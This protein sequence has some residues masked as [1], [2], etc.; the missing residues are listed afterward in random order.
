M[1]TPGMRRPAASTHVKVLQAVGVACAGLL[2]VSLAVVA[3][4]NA[5][6]QL[7]LVPTPSRSVPGDGLPTWA[8][9]PRFFPGPDAPPDAPQAQDPPAPE[10]EDRSTP[11]PEAPPAPGTGDPSAPGPA[12]D[13]LAPGPDATDAPDVTSPVD[14]AE[15]TP[16]VE[17]G[18]VVAAASRARDADA[19]QARPS[20]T[21]VP[22]TGTAS[23]ARGTAG[24]SSDAR[25]Q[26]RPSERGPT[27]TGRDAP[28]TA[29]MASPSSARAEK[30]T[31]AKPQKPAQTSPPARA[32]KPK[33]GK[34]APTSPPPRAEK[35]TKATPGK[36]A[37]TSPP[38]RAEKPKKAKPAHEHA[39]PATPGEGRGRGHGNR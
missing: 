27:S 37:H 10:T 9:P 31:K 12:S 5:L 39:T 13:D 30:P 8:A 33:P 21:V 38:A 29:A 17:D 11:A 7:G 20:E 1:A 25:P 22:P 32:V 35:P 18:L 14:P 23:G 26:A 2:A 28:T 16:P 24:R 6:Q 4:P 36:P 19:G 15:T 34:P 3:Q